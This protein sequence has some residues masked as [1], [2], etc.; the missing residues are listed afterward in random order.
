MIGKTEFQRK[1]KR[2]LRQLKMIIS[3][4]F[5]STVLLNYEFKTIGTLASVFLGNK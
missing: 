4:M 2:I 1:E 5:F 3:M